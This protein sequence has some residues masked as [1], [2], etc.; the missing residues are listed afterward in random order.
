MER[1]YNIPLRREWLKA[2]RYQRTKKAVRATKAFLRRHMKTMDVRLGRQLNMTLWAQG[3][4]HPPHLVKVSAEVVKS[5]GVEF[6]YAELAGVPKEPLKKAKV[7]KKAGLVGKL[8]EL[9]KGEAKKEEEKKEEEKVLREE[10]VKEPEGHQVAAAKA[11][12][13][14]KQVKDRTRNIFAGETRRQRGKQK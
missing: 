13:K 9:T 7:E 11:P 3:Y 12:E 1:L 10:S 14:E 4:R 8:E 2:P 6:V 5:D